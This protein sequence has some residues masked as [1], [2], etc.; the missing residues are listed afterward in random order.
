M[1]FDSFNSW[2]MFQQQMVWKQR[3]M[4]IRDRQLLEERM[5][6]QQQCVSNR[7]NKVVNLNKIDNT[8]SEEQ[9]VFIKTGFTA[10]NSL[11]DEKCKTQLLEI[12]SQKSGVSIIDVIFT[13]QKMR[14][15]YCL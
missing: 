10:W 5:R 13:W 12:T 15:G 3:Q 11:Q 8:W 7:I 1:H 14:D 6:L 9:K 2:L 4:A